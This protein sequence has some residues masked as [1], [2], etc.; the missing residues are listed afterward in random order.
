MTRAGWAEIEITPP[1][2]LPMGGRGPRF[3]PGA[4]VL[5]Q[6]RAQALVLEDDDGRRQLWL[7]LDLIGM[8]HGR[9]A[10]LRQTLAAVAGVPHAGVVL[11]F[12]HVH[13]GPMTNF[14]KYPPV[15]QEPE[16][17]V[18]YHQSL[19]LALRR[20][21]EE[22]LLAMQPVTVAWHSGTSDVGI[23]RRLRRSDGDMALAPNPDGVYNPDLWILDLQATEGMDRAI[24]FN[25][26]CHPVIVYG[27]IWDGISAG[28]P[29][30]ARRVLQER[31]IEEGSDAVHCQ[32]IQGLAG[33]VRP[34][35]LADTEAGA[36]RKSRPEDV[37]RAGTQLAE[38]VLT[39]IGQPGEEL[40]LVLRATAGWIAPRRALD[41][42]PSLDHWRAMAA[43]DD[44]LS[45][46]VGRYW[47]R[48]VT[49]GRPFPPVLP[50]EIGLLQIAE[51]HR[52]AW[53]NAEA[54]AEWM[55]LLRQALDDPKLAV[56]GY[57]QEV[58]TYLPTDALLPEGD[59]E[60]INANWYDALGPAPF[61][62]GIDTTVREGFLE[63]W[64]RL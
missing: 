36:F 22:A 30:V 26:G 57:C 11:N 16:L 63:L 52:V 1:L 8:D 4:E 28:Y 49:S 47:A 43:Q 13:S 51:G 12:A 42:A 23:N 48:R 29:G 24:I 40:S 33:N 45:R 9:A 17:L 55:P 32:F 54:V 3:A 18:A 21:V 39:A 14:H 46:N 60:V 61:A 64:S 31:L 41:Q 62:P 56:W 50:M 59:Y 27:F 25:Y 35:V 53:F 10:A 7:S 37:E 58:A 2:G 38:D 19:A 6:L 15:M 34:R 20:V 44:E 5:D